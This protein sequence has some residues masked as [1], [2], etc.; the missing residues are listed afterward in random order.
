MGLLRH[1]PAC[2]FLFTYI[3]HIDGIAQDCGN[4]SALA[5][6]LRQF[7]AKPSMSGYGMDE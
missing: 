1:F 4:S 2:M 6:E 3:E 5:M 7:C